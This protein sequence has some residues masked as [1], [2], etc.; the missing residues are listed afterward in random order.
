MILRGTIFSKILEMDTRLTVVGPDAA[1]GD[2]PFKAVYLLHGLCG[3]AE[4]WADNTMLPYYARYLNVLFILPEVGR[5]FYADQKYGQRYFSYVSRELPEL[6]GRLF[7]ISTRREDTA[8]MGGSMGGF[9]GLKCA[10]AR[11]EQFGTC[12]AFAPCCLF[13]P[14]QLEA[15]S[16]AAD[17]SPAAPGAWSPN[18]QLK[19]DFLAM[20]GPEL[21]LGETDDILGLAQKLPAGLRP[22]LFLACGLDDGFLPEVRRFAAEAKTLGFDTVYEELEGGH[23][24]RFF[25][26]ALERALAWNCGLDGLGAD[27][28]RYKKL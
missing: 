12:C 26:R 3:G 8:I 17:G 24:W 4:S 14:A 13:L 10:L 15:F 11:P 7:G 18:E 27:Q 28:G 25:D 6:A 16:R 1:G 2:G 5:S 20:L 23:N 19:R 21:R 22:R 9:G